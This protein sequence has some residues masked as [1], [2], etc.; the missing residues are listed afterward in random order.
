MGSAGLQRVWAA[1]K[2]VT[3]KA[4][5]TNE[6]NRSS[7]KYCIMAMETFQWHFHSLHGKCKARGWFLPESSSRSVDAERRD[8]FRK[9]IPATWLVLLVLESGKE[10]QVRCSAREIYLLIK[11]Q[12]SNKHITWHGLLCE[13]AKPWAQIKATYFHGTCCN[14][15][16]FYSYKFICRSKE[17]DR[18]FS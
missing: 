9:D 8:P 16:T 18:S 7:Q 10:L 14:D 4:P 5:A 12:T 11:C 6:Y 2:Q 17:A 1:G 3:R 15:K 13:E